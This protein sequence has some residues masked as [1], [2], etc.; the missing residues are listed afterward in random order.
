MTNKRICFCSD[1][2]FFDGIINEP[3]VENDPINIAFALQ[4][5]YK[6]FFS[7]RSRSDEKLAA[8][9]RDYDLVIVALDLP[10]VRLAKR[11]LVS[12]DERAA[13]YSE[14]HVT[15]YQ[16]LDPAGQCEFVECLRIA[17][18]NLLYWERYIGFYRALTSKPVFYL[19]YPYIAELPSALARESREMTGKIRIAIPSGLSGDTRNG[20][21]SLIVAK[22]LLQLGVAKQILC[23]SS[24]ENFAEDIGA[25]NWILHGG[26]HPKSTTRLSI[27]SIKNRI[28]SS[29]LNYRPLLKLKKL[30]AKQPKNRDAIHNDG[31]VIWHQR[32]NWKNYLVELSKADLMIDMNNR[33]TVGRNSLDC[34]ALGIPCISTSRSDLHER[35]YPTLTCRD[36]WDVDQAVELAKRLIQDQ[37]F[38]ESASAFAKQSLEN[39]N[40]SSFKKNF[41]MIVREIT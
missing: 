3:V 33:E 23:W 2:P 7:L 22:N 27:R 16:R 21:V 37:T 30:F 1:R 25:T 39:Y 19:P 24:S 18:I 13:T 5:D 29:G 40:V 32:T 9:F 17:K 20:L 41:E 6:S 35:L 26:N 38:C 10:N 4:G 15:D 31:E 14:G 12:C 36:P 28:V 11:I 8:T 34:A